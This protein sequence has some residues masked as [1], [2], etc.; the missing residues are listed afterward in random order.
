MTIR[1]GKPFT[2]TYSVAEPTP[3]RGDVWLARLDKVRP[4]VVLTRDPMGAFLHRVI[5]APVTSTVR[6]LA[7]EVPIGPEAGIRAQSVVNLDNAQL[8][9]RIR[10]L[11]RL[12]RVP[13]ITMQEI[14][15]ALSIAV[16]CD[17]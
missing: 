11:E 10:L 16:G 4:V 15:Q 1:T 17:R 7:T 2:R 14:C 12:G 9:P 8:V 5:A 3:R 6:G 13:P